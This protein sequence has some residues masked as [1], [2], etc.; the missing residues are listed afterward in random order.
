MSKIV[1]EFDLDNAAYRDDDGNLFYFSVAQTIRM[2]A[3]S[4]EDGKIEGAVS[5]GNG[6]CVGGFEITDGE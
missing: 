3:D 6:N 4:V 2:I 5:D 1:I